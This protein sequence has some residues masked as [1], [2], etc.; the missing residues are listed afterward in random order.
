MS[1]LTEKPQSMALIS[2]M[3]YYVCNWFI[4]GTPAACLRLAVH[5]LLLNGP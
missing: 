3:S 4:V 1:C 2:L 5:V